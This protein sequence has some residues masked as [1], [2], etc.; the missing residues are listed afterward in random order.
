MSNHALWTANAPVKTTTIST[1]T[2]SEPRRPVARL[3][4]LTSNMPPSMPIRLP[5]MI[6]KIMMN[7]TST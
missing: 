3:N 6:V 7:T 1:G 4:G 5:M 2:S